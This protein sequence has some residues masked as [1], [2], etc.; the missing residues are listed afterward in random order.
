MP[1][2]ARGGILETRSARLRLPPRK[3][4]YWVASGKQGLHLGYRRSAGKN[5]TWVV[6]QYQKGPR[7]YGTKAFAHADDYCAADEVAVLTYYQAIRRIADET[8]SVGR[9]SPY[10][11]RS[12]V[13]DYVAWLE[14]HRKSAGDARS[15]L[16]TYVTEYFGDK[17]LECL[18]AADFDKWLQWAFSHKPRGRMKD[19]KQARQ[20]IGNDIPAAERTRRRKSSLNRIINYLKAA[21]N[22]AFDD[23]HVSNRD[24]WS[25]L[26]KFRGADSARVA[27]LTADEARRLINACERDFR[28]LVEAA[29]L[30]GCRYGELANLRAADFDSRSGTLLVAESKSAKP[31]RVP[32]TNEGHRLFEALA[33]ARGPDDLLLTKADGSPWGKSEQFRRIGAA[34]SAAR[35]APA[36]TFH[37]LRHTF[38]SL[39]VEAG[40]PL[41]FVAA[42]LGHADTRMVSKH[43]QHLSSNVLHDAIRA[44]LPT[45]GVHIDDAV[46]KL[47]P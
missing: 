1:R 33:A 27:C 34:C 3:K 41:A 36:I 35:I 37:A 46:R 6:R 17:A 45:F 16:K 31:R 26:Q 44:N 21:L 39:L 29:L 8:P 38:A 9:N 11:V 30:T 43:Y 20:K 23:G 7:S 28:N 12:A 15:R 13:Q 4:P 2:T 25:R 10:S 22:R 47:R 19:G 32:L 14:L 24:A 18:A 42:T 40:T 5:G